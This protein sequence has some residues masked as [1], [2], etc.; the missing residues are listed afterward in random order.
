MC[1]HQLTLGWRNLPHWQLTEGR[2]AVAGG[3]WK[4]REDEKTK[5]KSC[6]TSGSR[7]H[8]AIR[9]SASCALVV[10]LAPLESLASQNLVVAKRKANCPPLDCSIRCFFIS[11]GETAKLFS[12]LLCVQHRVLIFWQNVRSASTHHTGSHE[13]VHMQVSRSVYFWTHQDAN[14]AHISHKMKQQKYMMHTVV[15][16]A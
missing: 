2:A 14:K 3:T 16:K 9:E 10:S 4:K 1:H 13:G 7:S 6:P 15:P 5:L 8:G 12:C 11:S